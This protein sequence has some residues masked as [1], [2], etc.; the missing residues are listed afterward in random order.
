MEKKREG[1]DIPNSLFKPI[2]DAYYRHVIFTYKG[3]TYQHFKR[4]D[5]DRIEKVLLRLGATYWEIELHHKMTNEEY[6]NLWSKA[7]TAGWCESF[8]LNHK[9]AKERID[10]LTGLL[11]RLLKAYNR[12]M[13]TSADI[14]LAADVEKALAEKINTGS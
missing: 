3:K 14:K 4:W 10:Q 1:S 6:Q 12:P 9:H 7:Y 8:D 5:F 13:T 2:R 11:R